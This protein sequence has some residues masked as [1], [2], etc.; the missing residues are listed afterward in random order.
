MR[1]NLS[2]QSSKSNSKGKASRIQPKRSVKGFKGKMI[3]DS[4][5]ESEDGVNLSV[6]DN[7]S[8]TSK[9]SGLNLDN[10]RYE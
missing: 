8:E 5:S 2:K 6:S 10:F 3:L 9:K 4:D 1:P 7:E